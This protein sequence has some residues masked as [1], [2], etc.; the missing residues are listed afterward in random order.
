MFRKEFLNIISKTGM[1]PIKD[2]RPLLSDKNENIISELQLLDFSFFDDVKF[3]QQLSKNYNLIFINLEK[4]KI[5][6][7]T[8]ALAKKS[9]VLK[10][11]MLPI[12][13]SRGL[14]NVAIYDPS[15]VEFKSRIQTVLQSSVEFI[16]TNLTSWKKIYNRVQETTDELLTTIEEI[17]EQDENKEI[18]VIKEEDIGQEVVT[19]VNK[20][21]V[22]AFV[23]KAS[24]IHIEPY[25]KVFRVRFRVDGDLTEVIRPPRRLMLPIISRIKIMAR[26]DIADRRK[27]Q[28]GRIKL[29]VG[30]KAIDY[31]VS[32]LPTLFG[33][34][35]VLR[36][37][38]SSDLELDMQKLGFE[39][40][41]I[42]RFRGGIHKPFGMCLVT[43]PTGS[44][45]TTTLYSSLY[46]LNKP[47]TNI[48]T[49]EDPVEFNFEGINQVNISKASGLTF[50]S[51][52][53]AFLR[54]DP[55]IIMIGE[56]RDFEV[57]EI[58]IEAALT[59]HLVLSTLHTNDACSTV[60]RLL[61]MGIEP[62]LV[63]GSLNV[64]VAQRLCKQI[65]LECKT[66]AN[67]DINELIACGIAPSSAVKITTYKGAGCKVCNHTGYKGRTA[68]YEVL[69]M[70]PNLRNLILKNEPTDALKKQAVIDGMKTLR[71]AALT[72]VAQGFI[73]LE[74][75]VMNSSSDK[76][77]L[78]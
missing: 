49:A 30:G 69:T 56:I 31:R 64:V 74:E 51:A 27:P 20:I 38:D 68:I 8:I 77:I 59:G 15:I 3:A 76:A 14:I 21:L 32:S 10:Y 55:D 42:K 11:R 5:K 36:L 73:T 19:Y 16:L 48:S 2:L 26:L 12:K 66:K 71:M 13:Q 61:N 44:G 57:A 9:D 40:R 33:E 75:A 65:C 35:V 41:Q 72:K 43:G 4:A 47:T 7:S 28:D 17:K 45:K 24:D 22:D 37:L 50:A 34:K 78:G 29:S 6:S 39:Q 63:T 18:E 1:I 46:E 23:K 67:T 25:E 53:K 58:A 62:F 70:T 54:Q 60:T 52:L